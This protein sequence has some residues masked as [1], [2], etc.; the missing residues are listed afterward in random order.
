VTQTQQQLARGD[1][2]TVLP[3]VDGWAGRTGTVDSVGPLS[4]PRPVRVSV[5]GDDD[6]DGRRFA[7]TELELIEPGTAA[8]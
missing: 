7:F 2:V 3:D 5:D 8:G 4:L 6:P 1:R